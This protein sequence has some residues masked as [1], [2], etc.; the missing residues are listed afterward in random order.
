MIYVTPPVFIITDR[1]FP[2]LYFQNSQT[3]TGK[4]NI[5]ETQKKDRPD[6]SDQINHSHQNSWV[7]DE[8]QELEYKY[9]LALSE[10]D[11]IKKSMLNFSHDLRNPLEGISGMIDLII[12]DKDRVEV[13]TRDLIIIK[14]AAQSILDL[15][16]NSLVIK[17]AQTNL[18]KNGKFHRNHFSIIKEIHRVYLPM[19][20]SKDI[21]LSLRSQ[22]DK[23]IQ[24]TPKFFEN[25]MQITGNLVANAVKFTPPKGSV[26][27]VFRLD[28]EKNQN[29]LNVTV[30]DTGKGMSTDQVS[31]FNQGKPVKRTNGTNGERGFGIGLLLVLQIVSEYAG[32]I[33]LKRKKE[34]GTEFSLSFPLTDKFLN[35]T[36]GTH[37]LFKNIA[38]ERNGTKS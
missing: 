28:V 35:Q 11:Q 38:L 21:S 30:T 19:A 7:D 8:K 13:Q 20:R 16:Q 27:V 22:T 6:I 15:I 23:E 9:S 25:L 36:N 32:S 5:M 1:W 17:D 4:L 34:V 12:E 2:F 37:S 3:P 26:D 18:N 24:L 29:K 33:K 14:E 10:L 31:A